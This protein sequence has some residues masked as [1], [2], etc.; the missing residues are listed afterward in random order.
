MIT[1]LF[2]PVSG[3]QH[4]V[5]GY[6]LSTLIQ[7]RIM[8][9]RRAVYFIFFVVLS[10]I[11]GLKSFTYA[12]DL[13]D[14]DYLRCHGEI[15]HIGDTK[16]DVKDKCGEPTSRKRGSWESEVWFYD[17]GPDTFVHYIKFVGDKIERIQSGGYG[18]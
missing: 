7:G 3:N 2:Y 5:S 17:F 15:V 11:F 6:S 1:F 4:L 14:V 9:R 10:L 13:S 8:M 12:A 18:S 16:S